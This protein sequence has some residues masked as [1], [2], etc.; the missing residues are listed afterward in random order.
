MGIKSRAAAPTAALALGLVFTPP[1]S[2]AIDTI[3]ID[4]VA[5]LVPPA[6]GNLAFISPAIAQPA[7]L[8]Q[9]IN[10]RA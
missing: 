5:S 3:I 10:H 8:T 4:T 7:A 6:I 2:I 9:K 1:A